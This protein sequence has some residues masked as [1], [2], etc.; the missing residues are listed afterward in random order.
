LHDR[1]TTPDVILTDGLDVE[2]RCVDD[3]DGANAD[4]VLMSAKDR[5]VENFMILF[6]RRYKKKS[7]DIMTI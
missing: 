2:T 1:S 6:P 7:D 5:A 3:D 4:A